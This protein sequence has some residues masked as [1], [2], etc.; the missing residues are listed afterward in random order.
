M[1]D[2]RRRP[3]NGGYVCMCFALNSQPWKSPEALNHSQRETLAQTI[4]HLRLPPTISTGF[5]YVMDAA[6]QRH[7][8]TMDMA[9]SF[10]VCSCVRNVMIYPSLIVIPSNL[11]QLFGF[12]LSRSELRIEFC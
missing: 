8:L 12:Y 5:L 1:T 2:R 9:H 6:G 7:T 11:M 10:Q 3:R 4:G